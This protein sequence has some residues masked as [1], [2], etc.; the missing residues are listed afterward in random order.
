MPDIKVVQDEPPPNKDIVGTSTG[1]VSALSVFRREVREFLGGQFTPRH[2]PNPCLHRR[3]L[4][5]QNF[6]A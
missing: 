2:I 4:D 3:L 6:R 5:L 1:S